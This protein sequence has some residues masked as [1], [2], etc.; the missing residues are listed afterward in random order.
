VLAEMAKTRVRCEYVARFDMHRALGSGYAPPPT[1]AS[2][3]R[4]G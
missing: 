4:A 1:A 3:V 2:T